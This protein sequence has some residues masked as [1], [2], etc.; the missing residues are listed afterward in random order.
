MGIN[1][2]CAAFV[3]C[4]RTDIERGQCNGWEQC[5]LSA[6]RVEY[7]LSFPKNSFDDTK[8]VKPNPAS[9]RIAVDEDEANLLSSRKEMTYNHTRHTPYEGV[10]HM[11][12]SRNSHK[13]LS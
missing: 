12:R 11:S 2:Y 1:R 10:D 6:V 7:V 8:F 13:H 4:V 3:L 5:F 9:I